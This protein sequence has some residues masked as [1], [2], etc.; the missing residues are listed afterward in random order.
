MSWKTEAAKES[1]KTKIES[2]NCFCIRVVRVGGSETQ[3]EKGRQ[4]SRARDK[5][6]RSY[7]L[8]E[9]QRENFLAVVTK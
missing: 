7:F 8:P 9:E 4:R 1:I 6:Q 5:K 2:G 3:R